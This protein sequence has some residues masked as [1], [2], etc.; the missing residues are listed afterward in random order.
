MKKQELIRRISS[1]TGVSIKKT[2]CVL[3]SILDVIEK[4]LIDGNNISLHNFGAFKLGVRNKKAFYNIATR[5]LDISPEH[6][7]VR[8]VPYKALKKACNR[9]IIH[10]SGHEEVIV[11]TTG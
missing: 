8:F 7:R 4:A 5:N 2:A 10:N 11:P 1:Q 3:Q 6:A 9:S